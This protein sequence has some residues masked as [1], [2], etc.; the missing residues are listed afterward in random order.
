M[1]KAAAGTIQGSDGIQYLATVLGTQ[2]EFISYLV[3]ISDNNED[4]DRWTVSYSIVIKTVGEA[5][6]V[7]S[8]KKLEEKSAVLSL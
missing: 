3:E 2:G 4:G 8:S 1:Y 6:Q 7:F 5:C